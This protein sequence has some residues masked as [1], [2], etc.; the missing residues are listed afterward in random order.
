MVHRLDAGTQRYSVGI[1][2]PR[3]WATSRGDIPPFKS[4]RA[5]STFPG[6]IRRLRPPLRPRH[7]GQASTGSLGQQLPLHLRQRR[8][9]VEEEAAG[10][11]RRVDT[12]GRA[13]VTWNTVY[14]AAVIDQL[15]AEVRMVNEEDI[16]RLSL[17]RYEHINPYGK[18]RFEVEKG[19]SRSRLRLLR[20][21]SEHQS[22]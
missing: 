15:Q 18:Y 19:L 10:R 8:H 12:V 22:P 16:A 6:V 13:V 1:E 20:Q 7:R 4:L 5:D 17:A 14:M 21:P 11:G 2:T 3:F 9:D